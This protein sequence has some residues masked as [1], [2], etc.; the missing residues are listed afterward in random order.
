MAREIGELLNLS[1]GTSSADAGAAG[2]GGK[3]GGGGGRWKRGRSLPGNR[4]LHDMME[5]AEMMKAERVEIILDEKVSTDRL[6]LFCFLHARFRLLKR[7]IAAAAKP[8]PLAYA[9]L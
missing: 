8:Y 6:L 7:S 3:A 1:P 9:V 5:V 4:W 2:G